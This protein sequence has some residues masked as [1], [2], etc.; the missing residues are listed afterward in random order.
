VK[1]RRKGK[2]KRREGGREEGRKMWYIY[3]MEYY[4]AIKTNEIM[5]FTV[6]VERD[7][8]RSK[9]QILHGFALVQNV[10]LK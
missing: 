8:P 2:G 6:N 4:S 7:K 10:G 1:E 5:S 9:T 3:T